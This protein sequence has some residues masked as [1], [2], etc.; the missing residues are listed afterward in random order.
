MLDSGLDKHTLR[1]TRV[2]HCLENGAIPSSVSTPNEQNVQ[3]N[4]QS[5]ELKLRGPAWPTWS[6]SL[7]FVAKH[8][9]WQALNPLHAGCARRG[10]ATNSCQVDR[11]DP[12]SGCSVPSAT[13]GLPGWQ[14]PP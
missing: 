6:T 11:V 9:G 7:F 1:V 10:R 13:P 12:S 8:V 14:L 2:S 4:V 5:P 3:K